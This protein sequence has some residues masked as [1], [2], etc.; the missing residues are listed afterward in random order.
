M[1]KIVPFKISAVKKSLKRKYCCY[2]HQ[3]RQEPYAAI[4]NA[5]PSAEYVVY[6]KLLEARGLNGVKLLHINEKLTLRLE[7]SSVLAENF[8]VSSL[9]GDK[10]VDNI[11]SIFVTLRTP[12]LF[13]LFNFLVH[14]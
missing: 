13:S 3:L 12:S 9:N 11:V 5:G 7:K 2:A 4:L 14:L 10:Q 1:F 6:P 8:V